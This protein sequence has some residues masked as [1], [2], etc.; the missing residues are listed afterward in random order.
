MSSENMKFTKK[1]LKNGLRIITVPMA[2]SLT[3]TVL[4]LTST[5]SKYE[6]KRLN[7]ISHF[8]EHMCF[9]GTKKRPSAHAINSELDNLGALS[10]AF[11][12][13]EY[14]GYYAQVEPR[15]FDSALDILSDIFLNSTFPKEEIEKERG[16]IIGE[17][18]MYEDTPQD[19]VGDLF[20]DLLYGDQPAGWRILGPKKNVRSLLRKDF[21]EYRKKHYVAEST[22]VIVTGKFDEKKAQKSIAKAFSEVRTTPKTGKQRVKEAQKKPAVALGFKKTNQA[23]LVMGFRSFDVFDPRVPAAT[24]LASVLGS[25]MSSRLFRKIREEMGAGYYVGATNDFFTDHGFFVAYAGV[26]NKR[27]PEVIGAILEEMRRVRDDLVPEV[28]LL[29]TKNLMTG[30]LVAGLETSSSL[31]TYYGG[32]E[33]MGKPLMTPAEKA[34]LIRSVTALEVREVA[35]D[36]FNE[37]NLNL[38]IMGPFKDRKYFRSLLKL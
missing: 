7:G 17:I 2:Q 29:K 20:T 26:D 11:T 15:H 25:G 1:K 18:D 31:A 33:I 22:V 34:K 27:A 13:H 3:T 14:T 12:G 35:R 19:L 5:G 9:K 30:R 21:L 4:V 16:V 8:L 37:K 28:E 6:T 38:A 24:V 23:H 10:N 32:S 36:I